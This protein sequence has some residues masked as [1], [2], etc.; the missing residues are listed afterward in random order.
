MYIKNKWI[1]MIYKILL[2]LM[3]GYGLSYHMHDGHW[4]EFNYYTVLSNAVCFVYFL[5]AIFVNLR[6][7]SGKYAVSWHPRLEIA[8]MFCITVTF[9]IYNFILRPETFKMGYGD[10]FYTVRNMLEHYIVPIMVILDWLLF[11]PKDRLRWYDPATWLLIPIVYFLYILVRATYAGNIGNTSS[12]YPYGFIDINLHGAATVWSNAGWI[13]LGML[14]LAYII[15]L[16]NIGIAA[17][18][19]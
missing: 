15:Y 4:G 12:P 8:I 18:K 11:C 3:C 5:I 1:S 13:V 2:V 19:K 16:L 17:L 6:K 14:A 7:G 9:L 10:N